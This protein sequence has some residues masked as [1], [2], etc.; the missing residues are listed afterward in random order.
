MQGLALI[1][2]SKK[3]ILHH[4]GRHQDASGGGVVNV[5]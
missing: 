1:T 4:D 3:K 2:T 5:G